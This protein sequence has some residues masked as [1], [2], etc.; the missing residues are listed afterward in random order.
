MG[1]YYGSNTPP[2]GDKKRR[3]SDESSQQGTLKEAMLITWSVF[4]ALALPLG[5]LFGAV[6]GLILLFF[7]FTLHW[8]VGLGALGL[9]AL[10]LGARGIWE[11]RHP[12]V[13]K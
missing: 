4:Q 5:L 12:P 3:G 11:L 7:L 1:F 2:P 6:A 10:A 9:I 13:L 8:I